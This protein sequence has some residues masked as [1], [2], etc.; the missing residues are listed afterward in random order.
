MNPLSKKK[1]LQNLLV[2]LE[3]LESNWT[4]PSL[5]TIEVRGLA[6]DSRKVTP[7]ALFFAIQ[8]EK[9]EADH[10][11][12][13]AISKGAAAIITDRKQLLEEG[14]EAPLLLVANVRQ[15]MGKIAALFY[16]KPWRSLAMFGVTGTNGKTTISTLFGY[17]C[18][19]VGRP[20]GVIGTVGYFLPQGALEAPRTTPESI[21]LEALLQE[22]Q[23]GGWKAASLECSSHAAVLERLAGVELDLL[24]FSNL[25]QDHLDFHGSMEAYFDAKTKLFTNLLQQEEK[26]GRALINLDDK[27]G[28]RLLDRLEGK[29][30]LVSYGQ[31]IGADFRATEVYYQSHGTTFTLEA[32]G[33]SYLVRSPFIGL[34]NLYNV[35]AALA[36]TNMMGVE[37]RRAIQALREAPQIPGRLQ[38]VEGRHPFEVFID[39]AHTPDAL[40]NVLQTLKQLHPKRL[41]TLFGCGGNRDR[42]K[43]PLMGS[44]VDRY[45]DIGIVTSDNP[46]DEDPEAII[47]DIIPGLSPGKHI[48]CTDRREAIGKAI[49]LAKPGDI[50]LIAGKGHENYQEIA[51]ERR[52]FDDYAMTQAFLQDKIIL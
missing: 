36:A 3:I 4:L 45:V 40:E 10:F 38:R 50:L 19:A 23:K 26:K 17:L 41:I 32:K 42:A 39:Y 51:G 11:L 14:W 9:F 15:A 2:P 35:L 24:A 18:R 13:E 47:K 5:E 46:R 27:Y 48:L 16:E 49:S 37:L 43:R 29:L 1:T 12:P 52:F 33:K 25:S 22:I 8:G 44:I 31:R 6:Y 34:F 30:S 20:C 28:R 21:D 7:G